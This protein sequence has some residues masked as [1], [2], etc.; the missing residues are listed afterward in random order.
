MAMGYLQ[1]RLETRSSSLIFGF[2]VYCV[3]ASMIVLR[4][5]HDT[6]LSGQRQFASFCVFFGALI[7]GFVVEAWPRHGRR[8]QESTAGSQQ[9]QQHQ[10]PTTAAYDDANLF[11]RMTF[12]F[13]QDIFSKGSRQPLQG[14]D[15]AARM[16][17]RIQTE[18]SHANLSHFW[19]RHVADRQRQGQEPSLGWITFKALGWAGWVPVTL[20][21]FL[22]SILEFC[23]ITAST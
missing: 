16:P 6:G 20:Y 3:L 18:F 21:S 15:I 2:Y 7:L 4:T 14:E 12:H 22:Q 17:S 1:A 9:Q 13:V 11:S 10:H 23:R 19:N 8:Q 5:M